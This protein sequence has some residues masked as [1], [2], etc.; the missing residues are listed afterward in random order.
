MM[1]RA[2][3]PPK[4]IPVYL[5]GFDDVMPENRGFPKFLPR[6]GSKI[7]V[8]F[9]DPSGITRD[10]GSIIQEWKSKSQTSG[11]QSKSDPEAEVRIALTDVLQRA[12]QRLGDKVT[13]KQ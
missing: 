12:V 5:E 9:G 1:L 11:D 7:R 8:T 13:G 3:V 10:A 6:L 2:K 4:V